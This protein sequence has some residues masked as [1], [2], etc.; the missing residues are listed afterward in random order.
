MTAWAARVMMA[1]VLSA[2]FGAGCGGDAAK[3]VNKDKDKPK[4]AETDARKS[5]P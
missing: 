1:F 4:A 5:P 3:G 2:V